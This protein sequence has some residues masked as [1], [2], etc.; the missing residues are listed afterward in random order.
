M[1]SYGIFLLIFML[2]RVFMKK[3]IIGLIVGIILTSAGMA[4]G[5]DDPVKIVLNGKEV[6]PD[7]P[8][9]IIDGR[10]FVPL[11][12]VA[13][14]L[15]INVSWDADNRTVVMTTPENMPPYSLVSYQKLNDEYG[16]VILGEVKN[17]SNK[18]YSEGKVKAE[19]L[20]AGGNVIEKLTATLP[21]GITPGETAY[22][23]MRSDSDKRNLVSSVKFN[24]SAKGEIDITPAEV[25]FS[26][27]RF[28]RDPDIYNDFI[29]VT[30]EI[31][32]ADDDLK[33]EYNHPLVQAA[34]FDKNGKLV[35]FGERDVDDFEQ[36]K[37]G[38]F[39]ITLEKGPDYASYKLK[40][41]SD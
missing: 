11:R 23:K 14:S 4:A 31:E 21:P 36:R 35:N 22:F 28:S 15:G 9:Q 7:T 24:F 10:T 30:G 3:F 37:Y 5:A 41:F 33:R 32:R 6:Q 16:Y 20:D 2:G 8:P 13:E 29:Y 1:S 26:E 38:E 34:L 12:F 19:V 17:E 40:F 18:T 25:S 39:K 27:V